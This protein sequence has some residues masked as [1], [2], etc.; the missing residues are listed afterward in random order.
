MYEYRAKI[1]RCVDGDTVDAEVDLGFSVTIKERFR[2]IGINT[3]ERGKPGF[4]E[5]TEFLAAELENSASEHDGWVPCK[6]HKDKRGKYGRMLIDFF[7]ENGQSI[8][9]K[10]VDAGHALDYWP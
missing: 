1:E 5:A 3:P 10:L 7:D 4:V 6:T 9:R 2:L 8:N